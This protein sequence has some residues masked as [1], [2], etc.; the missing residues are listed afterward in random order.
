MA[1]TNAEK[2][3][4]FRSKRDEELEFLRLQSQRLLD[5]LRTAEERGQSCRLT[6]NLPEETWAAMAALVDRLDGF[7]LVAFA[8]NG[9]GGSA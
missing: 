3:A 4:R 5:A 6:D 7:K 1:L 9:K 8:A 2:Q